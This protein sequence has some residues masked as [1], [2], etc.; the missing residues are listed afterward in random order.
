MRVQATLLAAMLALCGIGCTSLHQA[1]KEFAES[2]HVGV[3]FSP[4]P[5]GMI[6]LD[7]PVF[8]TSLGYIG[9]SAWVGNDYGYTSGWYQVA[10]FGA[11]VAQGPRAIDL[12]VCRARLRCAQIFSTASKSVM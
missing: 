10:R 4:R 1:G 12:I 8:G 5:A 3:G 7:L 6:W 11:T 2:Y 9:D